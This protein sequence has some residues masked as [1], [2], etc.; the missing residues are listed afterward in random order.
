VI[1]RALRRYRQRIFKA[2]HER[3]VR[4]FAARDPASPW[5]M[6]EEA[7]VGRVRVEM[8]MHGACCPGHREAR[9]SRQ[10]WKPE[11]ADLP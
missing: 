9:Y 11:A 2:A 7:I 4:R 1:D 3:R 5:F 8:T 6:T 10:P